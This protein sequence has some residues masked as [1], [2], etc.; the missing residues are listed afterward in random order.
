MTFQSETNGLCPDPVVMSLPTKVP[1]SC[2]NNM[3]CLLGGLT[4]TTDPLFPYDVSVLST[5]EPLASLPILPSSNFTEKDLE[6]RDEIIEIPDDPAAHSGE[7]VEFL[8]YT[9]EDERSYDNDDI[10]E[11]DNNGY[12]DFVSDDNEEEQRS[13]LLKEVNSL[14]ETINKPEDTLPHSPQTLSYPSCAYKDDSEEEEDVEFREP[15]RKNDAFDQARDSK[16]VSAPQLVRVHLSFLMLRK[17]EDEKTIRIHLEAL[18]ERARARHL[19]R[20][21]REKERE[22]MTRVAREER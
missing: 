19:R 7:D 1:N 22:A 18:K 15:P 4:S 17:E 6:T 21:D 8:D 13:P 5:T 9:Q 12:D 10:N 11:C 3:A 20:L 16:M 14:L 2:S